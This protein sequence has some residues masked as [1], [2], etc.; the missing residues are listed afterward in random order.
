[1]LRPELADRPEVSIVAPLYNEELNVDRFV[2]ELLATL[3]PL[4]TSFEIILVD[5]GSSDD[6]W[7]RISEIQ[8]FQ[9]A[10]RG[11]SLLRNFGHQRALLAGLAH[12]S[13]RAVISMDG[14]LQHPPALIPRLLEAWRAGAKVVHT[15]RLDASDTGAFKRFTSRAFYW[16]FSKLSGFEVPPGTS[17]FRLVDAEVLETLLK[18]RDPEPFLRGMIHW[19]GAP[20]VTVPYRARPRIEG[21]SKFTL[22]KMIGLSVRGLVSFT[23]IPLRLGIWAAAAT[24]LLAFAEIAYIVVQYLRGETVPGWASVL[25]VVSF[26]FGALFLLLGILGTYVASIHESVRNRP[27][28]VV[29][30]L[31]GLAGSAVEHREA[32]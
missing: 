4:V 3:R 14:D 18:L 29:G 20:G 25:T 32:G 16:I 31:C 12:A 17:D 6:T 22:R 15:S 2:A 7:R 24:G 11:I 5:D 26:M 19:L 9:P 10:V 21:R 1:M 28:F 30:S 13:G 23:T 8:R 27:A